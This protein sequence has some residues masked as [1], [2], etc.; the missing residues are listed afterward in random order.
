L[1]NSTKALGLPKGKPTNHFIVTVTLYDEAKIV[2][3]SSG[4]LSLES[5]GLLWDEDTS[6]ERLE[7]IPPVTIE[8]TEPFIEDEV[9]KAH[10]I[11]ASVESKDFSGQYVLIGRREED[12]WTWTTL[13]EE[14]NPLNNVNGGDNRNFASLTTLLFLV[15]LSILATVILKKRRNKRRNVIGKRRERNP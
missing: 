7:G 10:K 1:N 8:F 14:E 4:Y 11:I 5:P 6:S 13:I 15:I 3:A 12:G 2:G 9:M